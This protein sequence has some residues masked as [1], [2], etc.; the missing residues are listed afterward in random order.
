MRR[1]RDP[2]LA[3]LAQDDAWK[4]AVLLLLLLLVLACRAEAP[5]PPKPSAYDAN[6]FHRLPAPGALDWLGSHS[7]KGQ[8]YKQFLHSYRVRPDARRKVL[9]LQPIGEVD[10]QLL[11]KLRQFMH[12]FFVLE[13]RVLDGMTIDKR[14]T[15]RMAGAETQY[16]GTDF[17]PILEKRLPRD[18]FAILGVMNGDMY[19]RPSWGFAFGI[20]SLTERVGVYSLARY[21]RGDVSDEV[22]LRRSCKVLAHETMH[23]FGMSHCIWYGCVLNGSNSLPELDRTPLQACPVELRK[24]RAAIH[25]DPIERYRRLR[26]FCDDA[27]LEEDARWLDTE[28]ARLAG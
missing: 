22:A 10:P 8:N 23:M 1:R 18:G 26:D 4:L 16:L 9:Y 19:P 12:A 25:F 5:A 3:A 2:S 11:E 27:G 20:A 7:E 15:S 14:V 17:F 24:L 6:G 28:I 21:R 13:V